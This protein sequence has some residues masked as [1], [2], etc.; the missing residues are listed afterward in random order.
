[1]RLLRTFSYACLISFLVL[2]FTLACVIVWITATENGIRKVV[3]L[4]PYYV[5]ELSVSGVE[6]TLSQSLTIRSLTWQQE[7]AHVTLSNVSASLSLLNL[8]AYQLRFSSLQADALSIHIKNDVS[9]PSTTPLVLPRISLPLNLQAGAIALNNATF[10]YNDETLFEGALHLTDTVWYLT[11]LRS[12][13]I[14]INTPDYSLA[15]SL[16]IAFKHN[17]PLALKANI[18]APP[19]VTQLAVNASGSLD[20]LTLNANYNQDINLQA[21][22]LVNVLDPTLPFSTV[23]TFLNPQEKHFAVPGYGITPHKSTLSVSGDLTTQTGLLNTA[24]LDTVYGENTLNSKLSLQWPTLK[25]RN[26]NWNN[27][28]AIDTALINCDVNVSAIHW[29]CQGSVY[30]LSLTHWLTLPASLQTDFTTQGSWS[31][32]HTALSVALTNL[33]AEVANEYVTGQLAINMPS[34]ETLHIEHARLQHNNDS[35]T[36]K[37]MISKLTT[38]ATSDLS[39]TA[40]LSELSL[41]DP[42]LSGN[43][44]SN[45]KVTGSL[46]APSILG[47][48]QATKIAYDTHA[49]ETLESHFNIKHWGEK[50]STLTLTVGTIKSNAHVIKSGTFTLHGTQKHYLTTLAIDAQENE[51]LH[52]ACSGQFAHSRLT[53]TCNDMAITY[54]IHT[55]ATTFNLEAPFKSSWDFTQQSLTTDGFCLT[56]AN[57]KLC[58]IKGIHYQN[59]DA[60]VTVGLSKI[61]VHWLIPTPIDNFQIDNTSYVDA[62]VTLLHSQPLA[63]TGHVTSKNLGWAWQQ[64]EQ[65]YRNQFETL[66]LHLSGD[67]QQLRTQ[68]VAS[69]ADGSSLNVNLTVQDPLEKRK[70]QGDIAVELTSLKALALIVP[71]VS[72]IEGRSTL[73]LALSGTAYE[74]ILQGRFEAKGSHLKLHQLPNRIN[75]YQFDATFN[76]HALAYRSHFNIDTGKASLKGSVNW[77]DINNL[78]TTHE[79]ALNQFTLYPLDNAYANLNANLTVSTAAQR[80]DVSGNIDFN[81]ADIELNELPPGSIGI[82]PDAVI[83]DQDDVNTPS[84]TWQTVMNVNVNLGDKFRFHGFGADLYLNGALTLKQ[85]ENAIYQ[86]HGKVNVWRG[87]YRAYGQRLDVRKG[88]LVFD[89]PL[90]NPILAFEAIRQTHTSQIAGIRVSGTLKSPES[91]LFSEPALLETETAYFVLTGKLPSDNSKDVSTDSMLIAMGAT[92]LSTGVSSLAERVGIQDFQLGASQTADGETQTHVSGY[93]TPDLYVRYGSSTNRNNNTLTLQYQLTEK[94]LIESVTGFNSTLDLLYTFELD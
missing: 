28:Q 93:V 22:M 39:L 85:S 79:L 60:S 90:D 43:I 45:I 32:E 91:E 14:E 33:N 12:Q 55:V 72:E 11:K 18:S 10:V 40:Q 20:E 13:R 31:P 5:P 16:R 53:H 15:T 83:I 78:T 70:I 35:L 23:V 6:G 34:L 58:A 51:S 25:L 86:A 47:N 87:R 24:F 44:S 41:V 77:R 67:L 21:D 74:P 57:S 69:T 3:A 92:G 30:A 82:S 26:I 8:L 71:P 48:I 73:N 64:G 46:Y 9:T 62:T 49:L 1:M 63:F 80:I 36:A 81:E 19:Y 54:P 66:S 37:G 61:P 42:L 89:G 4:I 59:K 17:Y 7:E 94:I 27:G 38:T 2:C 65:S 56:H 75:D 68:V 84:S 52:A 76:K 88:E 29:D 50:E